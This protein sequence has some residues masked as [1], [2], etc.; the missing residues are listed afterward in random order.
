MQFVHTATGSSVIAVNND[1]KS[2]TREVQSVRCL[3]PDSRRNIVL[4]ET[5]GF[6]DTNFSDA[7]ILRITAHWLKE[8]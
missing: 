1:L 7:Q 2:K 8:T 5:P 6:D 4:V 3:H